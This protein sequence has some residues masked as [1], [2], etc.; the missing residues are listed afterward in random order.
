ANLADADLNIDYL[1]REMGYSRTAFYLKI[2]RLTGN[3]P[4]DFVRNFRFKEAAE[5]ISR[6]E[7]SLS[8]IAEH[9]GFGSY[10]YFSKAFKKHFGVSPKEYRTKD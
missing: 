2:K 6:G 1:A 8:D 7:K 10:S 9:T 3:S 5:A 4:N